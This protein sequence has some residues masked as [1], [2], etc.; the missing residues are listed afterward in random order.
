[1]SDETEGSPPGGVGYKR[2]PREYRFK[3]GESGN[4]SGR[5]KRARTMAAA[6]EKVLSE[7]VTVRD[8]DKVIKITI[9][10]AI[11]RQA[12]RRLLSGTD[13]KGFPSLMS[14]LKAIG[15]L[16]ASGAPDRPYGVLVVPTQSASAEE[17][18]RDHGVAARGKP[19]PW[20]VAAPAPQPAPPQKAAP[21][22]PFGA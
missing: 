19:P 4:P 5:P 15:A 17:W 10:E 7:I 3:K 20:E 14:A 2:P 8:G 11:W 9:G 12:V 16:K 6:A 1:M 21:L 13:S 22:L 18:E